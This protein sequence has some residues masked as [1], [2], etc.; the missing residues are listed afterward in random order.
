MRIVSACHLRS[1]DLAADQAADLA[2]DS[3]DQAADLAADSADLSADAADQAADLAADAADQ[4]ADLADQAA[5]LAA[6]LAADFNLSHSRS[7]YARAAS[8]ALR[9]LSSAGFTV[10]YK[11]ST[12]SAQAIATETDSFFVTSPFSLSI[13]QSQS[14]RSQ[15]AHTSARVLCLSANLA[16]SSHGW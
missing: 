11:E 7:R 2:A 10:S 15:L 1:A 9:G 14:P 3:A 13:H 16:L 5:D 12:R 4:A 6:D 8:I